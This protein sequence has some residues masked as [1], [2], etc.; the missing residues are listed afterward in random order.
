MMDLKNQKVL[1]VGL[2]KTGEAL[3]NFLLQKGAKVWVSE[4]KAASEL[5]LNLKQLEGK[6]VKIETGGH[7]LSTFL[8]VDLIIPSPGVPPIPEIKIARE[9]G[10]RIMAEIELA[11]EFIKG[12]IIGITGTN[13][14]S[15]TTTLIHKIL[16]ADHRSSH[17]A[18]NIGTPLIR[19]A[20]T[21]RPSDI[22]VTEISSFQLEYCQHFR[23]E[24]AVFLN[25]SSNHLDWHGSLESYW[26]AKAKLFRQ[27]TEKDVAIL[28]R[29]DP[30][31]WDLRKEIQAPVYF[32]SRQVEVKPGIY[33]KDGWFY[34]CV[35]DPQPLLPLHAIKLLGEHNWENIMASLLIGHLLG[36]PRS[37]MRRTVSQFS[38]LEHRLE[39]VATWRGLTFYNDSK[40]TTVEATI[41]A[42]NALKSGIIL[43]MGG[44][45]KGADF[46][47][48]RP[49]LEKVRHLILLGEAKEKIK[50]ALEGTVPIEEATTMKEAII[51]AAEVAK[52]GEAILLSPACTSFDMFRDFEHRGRVFKKE[53]RKLIELKAKN[54]R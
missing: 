27:L 11:R 41:K 1:V 33:L 43:I 4:K 37:V 32:F 50:K 40:A 7:R 16:K 49:H 39:K 38:G 47:L 26:A 31:L 54:K 6:G 48:L 12:K 29:D 34:L 18:G 30:R 28:N 21:S 9:K 42:L 46:S 19:Y 5:K 51:K 3:V 14:K 45:D 44:R 24:I 25:F 52:K 2:G 53:V 36:V 8:N 23:C 10:K 35:N 20:L 13:G 15:T 22:Y 17:L